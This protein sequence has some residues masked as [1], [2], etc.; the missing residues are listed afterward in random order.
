MT[1]KSRTELT[2][3]VETIMRKCGI[4]IPE[5]IKEYAVEIEE[6]TKVEKS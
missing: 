5:K 6:D 3:A 1:D 4:V 2:R